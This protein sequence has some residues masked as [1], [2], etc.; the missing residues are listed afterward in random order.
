M[1]KYIVALYIVLMFLCY[2]GCVGYWTTRYA[3]SNVWDHRAFCVGITLFP[4]GA[5]MMPFMTGF[6]NRGFKL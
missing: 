3:D 4:T 1:I 2:P 6:Y 5:I